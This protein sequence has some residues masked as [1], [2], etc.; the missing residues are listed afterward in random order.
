MTASGPTGGLWRD[1]FHRDAD[2]AKNGAEVPGKWVAQ[3][4]R[5]DGTVKNFQHDGSWDYQDLPPG[6][7]A[8]GDLEGYF[9]WNSNTTD[10]KGCKCEH[11][12]PVSC[13]L[14]L[15]LVLHPFAYSY[16]LVLPGSAPGQYCIHSR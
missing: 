11:L 4:W 2:K 9:W 8:G 3:P 10:V 13:C 16:S 6:A 1:D 7:E 14:R 15:H 12:T 5:W